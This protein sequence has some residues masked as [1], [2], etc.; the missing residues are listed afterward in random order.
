[1]LPN[2]LVVRPAGNG[3][4]SRG[5]GCGAG[6]A[7]ARAVG[8]RAKD[9]PETESSSELTNPKVLEELV[10]KDIAERIVEQIAEVLAP[11][12]GVRVSER[13]M[14][15]I[16]DVSAP[17]KRGHLMAVPGTVLRD[18]IQQRVDEQIVDIASSEGFLRNFVPRSASRSASWIRSPTYLCLSMI[19]SSTRCWI[20]SR[21]TASGTSA[22][23]WRHSWRSSVFSSR[24]SMCLEA[25]VRK[26]IVSDGGCTFLQI[27]GAAFQFDLGAFFFFC[28]NHHQS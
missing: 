4:S 26:L 17:Q 24:S 15:Q 16:T 28:D 5:E 2:S 11:Q 25:L 3:A 9:C 13:V 18:E 8:G 20:P 22:K 23:E 6:A 21:N 14:E 27:R 12:M 1:M 19:C 7:N 10:E